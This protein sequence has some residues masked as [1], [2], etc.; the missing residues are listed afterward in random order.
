MF[1]RKKL[2]RI[3]DKL[4]DLEILLHLILG[5]EMKE[6]AAIDDLKAIDAALAADVQT[7]SAAVTSEI[8]RVE[9]IIASL[10][11]DSPDVVQAV[12]DLQAVK[13]SLDSAVTQLNAE[14][15]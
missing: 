9:A 7:L 3:I 5:K 4:E 14:R 8:A 1:Y 15:P 10:S 13:T 12:A 6:M 11:G 2:E